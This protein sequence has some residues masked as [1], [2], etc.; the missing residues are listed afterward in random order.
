MNAWVNMGSSGC[1]RAEADPVHV[2]DAVVHR[3]EAPEERHLVAEPVGPV[4]ADEH[5]RRP[6]SATAA[7][8]GS[9][10]TMSNRRT[11]KSG[12]AAITTSTIAPA[13]SARC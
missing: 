7:D 3:V 13:A 12:M 2:L 5:E 6:P 9:A 1:N 11:Q 10:P 4:L 8:V